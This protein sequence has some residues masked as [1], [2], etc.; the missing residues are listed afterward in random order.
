MN[1]KALQS[2]TLPSNLDKIENDAFYNC[3][4]LKSLTIPNDYVTIESCG[5]HG[6]LYDG[7]FKSSS[8]ITNSSIAGVR[9]CSTY[10][11][12]AKAEVWLVLFDNGTYIKRRADLYIA[13]LL[14]VGTFTIKGQT[15]TL[16]VTGNVAKKNPYVFTR[17]SGSETLTI[18]A[19]T[20]SLSKYGQRLRLRKSYESSSYNTWT[21]DDIYND[22]RLTQQIID[23]LKRDIQVTVY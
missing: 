17:I 15:L 10:I 19:K 14:E 9:K 3:G 4:K 11:N 6:T 8:K 12:G 18:N 16:K 2:V 13:E 22:R 7:S 5:F 1:C 21:S 20:G 23:A